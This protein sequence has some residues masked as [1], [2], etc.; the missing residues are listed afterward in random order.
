MNLTTQA[1]AANPSC[2]SA[3]LST[4]R[5]LLRRPPLG[6]GADPNSSRYSCWGSRRRSLASCRCNAHPR[7][8]ARRGCPRER[9]GCCPRRYGCRRRGNCGCR[10]AAATAAGREGSSVHRRPLGP[11]RPGPPA[12]THGAGNALQHALRAQ[13]SF[14]GRRQCLQLTHASA[15]RRR[16]PPPAAAGGGGSVRAVG[17]GEGVRAGGSSAGVRLGEV[18]LRGMGGGG[19][20]AGQ[21]GPAVQCGL[22]RATRAGL[23]H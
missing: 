12:I 6:G 5:P 11:R 3:L 16:R 4:P 22:G 17:G 9:L 7:R 19:S 1:L 18:G 10:R 20:S 8:R 13:N 14:H 2:C 15:R 21:G 23:R